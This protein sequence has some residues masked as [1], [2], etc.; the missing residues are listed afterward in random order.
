MLLRARYSCLLPLTLK[1]KAAVLGIWVAPC[2]YVTSRVYP[3]TSAVGP[4]LNVVQLVALGLNRWGLTPVILS[5]LRHWEAL[6][7]PP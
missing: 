6:H 4:Q 7:S 1:E 5:N 2:V 3:A